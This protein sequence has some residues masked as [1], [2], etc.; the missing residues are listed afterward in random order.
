M[1]HQ[2][3]KQGQSTTLG[4]TC[5]TLFDKCADSLTSLAN[6]VTLKMQEMGRMVLIREDLSV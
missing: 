3:V 2:P 1:K 6:H 4:T 5:P